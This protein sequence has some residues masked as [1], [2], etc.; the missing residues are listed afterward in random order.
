MRVF[1]YL[2]IFITPTVLVIIFHQDIRDFLEERG[3]LE[4]TE[5]PAVDSEPESR[6]PSGIEIPEDLPPAKET[7]ANEIK[8][9]I[10]TMP[11]PDIKS[12]EELVGN[13]HE[14]PKSAFP[15]MVVI[16]EPIEVTIERDGKVIGSSSYPEGRQLYPIS[17]SNGKLQVSA[18]KD[19]K[20]AVGSIDID[21]T[22]FKEQVRE[23]YEDWKT[24]QMNLYAKRQKEEKRRLETITEESSSAQNT[25]PLGKAPER[26]PDGSIPV[27]VESIKN[28]EVTEIKLDRISDWRWIGQEEYGGTTYWVGAVAY[29][30]ET[31]FGEIYAEG[32]ALIRDGKVV[33]WIYS[34]SEEEIK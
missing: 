9:H 14:V 7:I 25:D 4:G 21:A 32:K 28:G 33:K 34:G 19:G 2:L 8:R 6:E 17:L 20:G 11:R 3:W 30:A 5:A 15:E 18:S 29:L 27:M 12:L 16:N 1:W 22:N 13:W 10:E 23:K 31:I 26:L 24:R